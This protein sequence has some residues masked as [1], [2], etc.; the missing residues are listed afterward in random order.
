MAKPEAGFLIV[1]VAGR[2]H[3]LPVAAVREVLR[4][5][6]LTGGFSAAVPGLLGMAQLRGELVPVLELAELLEIPAP[7]GEEKSRRLVR[8]ELNQQGAARRVAFAVDAVLG[9]YRLSA[10][11]LETIA[12]PGGARQQWGAFDAGFAQLLEAGGVLPEQVWAG[13]EQAGLEQ[14]GL[15]QA[16]ALASGTPSAGTVA[17]AG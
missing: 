10:D 8:V 6:P 16:A 14:A 11:R 15:E 13:L 12:L 2:L 3:G 5:L 7:A 17:G 4:V 1:R 9:V